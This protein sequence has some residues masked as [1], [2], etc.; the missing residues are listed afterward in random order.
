MPEVD[1]TLRQILAPDGTLV[2]EMPAL[3]DKELVEN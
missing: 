2:G 1:T 3:D